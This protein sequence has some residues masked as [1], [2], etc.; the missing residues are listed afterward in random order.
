MRGALALAFLLGAATMGYEMLG[1]RLMAIHFGS[2]PQVWAAVISVFLGGLA[3]GYA[4]GGRLGDL[5]GRARWAAGIW[6]ATALL[7]VATHRVSRPLG[8][9]FLAQSG[10]PP[11]WEPV[12]AATALFIIPTI[13]MGTAL[14]LLLRLGVRGRAG[15]GEHAGRYLAFSTFGGIL[16]VLGTMFLLIPRF[17]LGTVAILLAAPWLLAAGFAI[18]HRPAPEARSA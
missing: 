3:V 15:E 18:L 16:G 4:I 5:P 8:E 6:G 13:G 1:P 14:P 11:W 2:I 9:W 12:A 17:P 7:V 10:T